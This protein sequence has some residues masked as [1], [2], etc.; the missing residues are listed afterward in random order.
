MVIDDERGLSETLSIF[1]GIWCCSF[2]YKE[3]RECLETGQVV[4]IPDIRLAMVRGG[5][6]PAYYKGKYG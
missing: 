4:R 5:I 3:L 2:I 1:G 6:L